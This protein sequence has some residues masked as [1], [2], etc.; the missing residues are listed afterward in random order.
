MSLPIR[1]THKTHKCYIGIS[2]T[3]LNHEK[4]QKFT[5]NASM[6]PYVGAT[7]GCGEGQRSSRGSKRL[8]AR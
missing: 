1:Q 2:L 4:V 6:P 7:R 8:V 5:Y 3:I